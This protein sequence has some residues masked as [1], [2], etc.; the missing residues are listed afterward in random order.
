[1][2]TRNLVRF[3]SMVDGEE[4]CS[5]CSDGIRSCVKTHSTLRG[6][7][8]MKNTSKSSNLHASPSLK[9]LTMVEVIDEETFKRCP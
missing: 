7:C 1:M 4:A 5:L 8:N 3:K 9:H 2:K 6:I